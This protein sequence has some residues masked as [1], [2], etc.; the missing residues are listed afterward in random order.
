MKKI[1]I[2]LSILIGVLA[3][4]SLV[5]AVMQS[6]NTLTAQNQNLNTASGAHLVIT[7]TGNTH[8]FWDTANNRLGIGTNAPNEKVDVIGKIRATEVVAGILLQL[9]LSPLLLLQ[10]E[11]I[12]LGAVS[13]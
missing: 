10:T 13:R 12:S 2:V 8:I 7:S 5:Y 4:I 6:L 11:S 1:K 9:Q 3:P